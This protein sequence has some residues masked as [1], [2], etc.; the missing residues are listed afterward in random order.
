VAHPNTILSGVD[1]FSHLKKE[2]GSATLK[3][4]LQKSLIPLSD[5][6]PTAVIG[7]I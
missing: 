7:L 1:R 2:L 4:K 3:K 5:K 6:F